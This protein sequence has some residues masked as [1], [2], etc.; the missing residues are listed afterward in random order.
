MSRHPLP[1]KPK[2]SPEQ[3]AQAL[4]RRV[5]ATMMEAKSKVK[6]LDASTKSSPTI[7]PSESRCM[8]DVDCS[9]PPSTT[10]PSSQM[11]SAPRHI[12]ASENVLSKLQQPECV[13]SRE[14]SESATSLPGQNLLER[15][16]LGNQTLMIRLGLPLRSCPSPIQTHSHSDLAQ[17]P[18][19]VRSNVPVMRKGTSVETTHGIGKNP[20][21]GHPGG[22]MRRP[23]YQPSIKLT[24]CGT[25]TPLTL[26]EPSKVWS[27]REESQ[28][29]RLSSGEMFL[30]TDKSTSESWPRID[31]LEPQS[32][33]MSSTSG[34]MSSSPQRQAQSLKPK[35][36]MTRSGTMLGRNIQKRFSLPTRTGRMSSSNMADISLA[37]SSPTL[38]PSLTSNMILP[39]ESSS[40]GTRISPLRTS[41]SYLLSPLKYS[42]HKANK[43][44]TGEM[45]RASQALVKVP[46]VERTRGSVLGV[47]RNTPSV[48][49]ST[50]H[51]VASEQTAA[52]S[53]NV[54]TVHR[55]VTQSVTA[56][57][58]RKRKCMSKT[59]EFEVRGKR[60]RYMRFIF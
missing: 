42:Y 55:V 16:S 26:S 31:T 5:G 20:E 8:R 59:R 47:H 34:I 19:A 21:V 9:R 60:P 58:N 53:T 28:T 45:I 22:M 39:H 11:N 50:G 41:M 1:P 6:L 23:L 12:T 24:S 52:S 33:T 18:K 10:M 48:A 56:H 14:V 46:D 29:S 32:M 44:G 51:P 35:S 2:I 3:P 57:G 27:L 38:T 25:S 4:E 40:M 36:L 37:D 30:Q 49:I 13:Q 15:M 43:E 54:P 17:I 7:L